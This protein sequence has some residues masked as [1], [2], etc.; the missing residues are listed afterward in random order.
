MRLDVFFGAHGLTSADVQGR[1]VVVIDVLRASTTIAVA[2]AHGARTVIPFESAE[3][4]H[5]WLP[6][7]YDPDVFDAAEAT[8]AMGRWARGVS[9]CPGMACPTRWQT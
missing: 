5:D 6:L 7:G 8:A 3:H 9:T 4:A 1:V 2:L